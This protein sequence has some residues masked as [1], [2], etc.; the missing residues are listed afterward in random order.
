V[1]NLSK[2]YPI[3]AKKSDRLKEAFHPLRRKFHRD[4]WALKN[5]SFDVSR[6]ETFGIIGVNGS[7]KSTLLGIICGVLRPSEGEYGVRG[8]VSALLE[9]GSG[10][11]PEFTGRENVYLQGAI[12]GYSREQ[13]E[14]RFNS[15]AAFADIGDFLDQPVK[16]Y[17]SGMMIRLAFSV[18]INVDLNVLIV[19]EVLAVGDVFFQAKCYAKFEELK[20]K[21]TTILLVSHDMNSIRTLCDKALCLD[22]G[23]VIDYGKSSRV[24]ETYFKN[25]ALKSGGFELDRGWNIKVPDVG[26]TSE[27]TAD[28]GPLESRLVQEVENEVTVTNNF[29]YGNGKAKLVKYVVNGA[30]NCKE[31]QVE[32][33]GVL[34]VETVYFIREDIQNPIFGLMLKTP[35]GIEI[36]GNNTTYAKKVLSPLSPGQIVRARFTQRLH[37]NN[38][39]YLLTMTIAEWVDRQVVYIDRRVDFI[40]LSVVGGPMPHI[41]FCNFE[42]AVEVEEAGAK[43]PFD[44]I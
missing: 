39:P 25:N 37:L 24:V 17:S 7:G 12:L 18:A 30:T 29:Q 10:F 28:P 4:F 19:D 1:R 42:G 9:L 22:G 43:V 2:K 5:V 13:I 11:N 33:N 36:Y 3:Y 35:I 31:V 34:E 6:G 26:S 32:S 15:I 21:N 38:G 40:L 27:L 44:V 8:R 41:G 23:Q 16:T 14:K 20:S